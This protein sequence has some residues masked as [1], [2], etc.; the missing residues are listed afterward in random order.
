M[1]QMHKNYFE[2]QVTSTPTEGA[3]VRIG[4]GSFYV[5]NLLIN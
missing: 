5:S 1:T 2:L 3:W 4:Q